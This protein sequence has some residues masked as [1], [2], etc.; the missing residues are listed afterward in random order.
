[1]GGKVRGGKV[2]GSRVRGGGGLI[3][4]GGIG[5]ISIRGIGSVAGRLPVYEHH[6]D[7]EHSKQ[8]RE[9]EDKDDP[10]GAHAHPRI[11]P[12]SDDDSMKIVQNATE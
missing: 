10:G 9:P 1:M 3:Q 7:C 6:E 12:E 4:V 5:G 11:L 2:R 8:D